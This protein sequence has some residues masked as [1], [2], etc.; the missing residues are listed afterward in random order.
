VALPPAIHEAEEESMRWHLHAL[1]M[2]LLVATA[3]ACVEQAPSA[4]TEEDLKAARVNIL[5]EAP[6]PKFP[7]NA[8]L[9]GRVTV[10]GCDVDTDVAE[11]GKPMTITTY[12]KVNQALPEG[13]RMFFHV[14]GAGA[15]AF[16]NFDHGPL[17]GK[18]PVSQWKAGE[19]LRDVYRIALPPS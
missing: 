12:W 17:G 8:D 14:N 15:S 1:T 16:I 2:G 19:I 7:V 10:L 18:Y 5:A 11:P 6:K 13:W 9:Q 4:P 3:S